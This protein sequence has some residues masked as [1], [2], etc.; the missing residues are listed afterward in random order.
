[1]TSSTMAS[2][3]SWSNAASFSLTLN[4][5]SFGIG[6]SSRRLCSPREYPT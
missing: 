1:M 6:D 2:F 3:G 5:L 4:A